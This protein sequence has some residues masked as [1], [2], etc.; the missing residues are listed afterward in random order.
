M[1]VCLFAPDRYEQQLA[2]AMERG[3][4]ACDRLQLYP[5]PDRVADHKLRVLR[6]LSHLLVHLRGHR[7]TDLPISGFAAGALADLLL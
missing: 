5:N 3:T 7:D 2:I 1:A 4:G 6:P